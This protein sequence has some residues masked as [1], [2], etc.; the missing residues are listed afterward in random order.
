MR[1]PAD[2]DPILQGRVKPRHDLREPAF[3]RYEN[4]MAKAATMRQLI[5]QSFELPIG[6]TG[7]RPSAKT[8]V[9]RFTDAKLGFKRYGYKTYLIPKGFDVDNLVAYEMNDDSV[10]IRNY[11]LSTSPI[12][13]IVST[14]RTTIM[15][16]IKDL[17]NWLPGCSV[18]V[19]I[20]CDEDFTWLRSLETPHRIVVSDK[21][22]NDFVTFSYDQP[23]KADFVVDD[24]ALEAQI[25]E[26]MKDTSDSPPTGS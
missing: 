18:T 10:V 16:I 6:L 17:P 20:A 19:K 9:A 25:R 26:M 22:A 21:D 2:L 3:R 12:V 15:L 4:V 23:V 8:F 5:L 11:A 1:R 7:R 14:D 24:P 13:P